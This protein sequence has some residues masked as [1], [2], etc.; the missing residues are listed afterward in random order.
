MAVFEAHTGDWQSDGENHYKTCPFC[1]TTY[2][3]G[4]HAGGSV[5]DCQHKKVCDTCQLEY[6]EAGPHR[7]TEHAA[8]AATCTAAGNVEYWSC[9][10]CHRNFADDSA[11]TELTNVVEPALGHDWQLSTWTWSTDYASASAR[12][13][14]A[15]DAGHTDFGRRCRYLPNHG[16]DCVSDGQTVYT[17][18]AS[19][20]GRPIRTRAPSPCPPPVTTGT[21][22]GRATPWVTGIN[23]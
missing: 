1:Q 11:A 12:F 17:A 2:A 9:S 22:R 6:G 20:E 8:V 15:R 16:P 4:A 14:C 5:V 13:T 19:F 23:A 21:V 10:V 3:R 7:L 18:S